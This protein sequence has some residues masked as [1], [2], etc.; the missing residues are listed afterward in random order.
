MLA[1]E[2]DLH[3]EIRPLATE[4]LTEDGDASTYL[5]MMRS[6]TEAIVDGLST[7]N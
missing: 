3:V 4:S 2:V 6:N 7:G 1:E 5:G